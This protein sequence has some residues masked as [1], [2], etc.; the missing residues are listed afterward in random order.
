MEERVFGL[1]K[2]K[3]SVE[4]DKKVIRGN[5]RFDKQTKWIIGDLWLSVWMEFL[6]KVDLWKGQIDF[7]SVF[8]WKKIRGGYEPENGWS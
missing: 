1:S 8:E 5:F 3:S 4:K 6:V 7:W 2:N